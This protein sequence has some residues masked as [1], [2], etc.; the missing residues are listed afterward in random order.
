MAR[1]VA[2]LIV[3]AYRLL[4]LFFKPETFDLSAVCDLVI[5]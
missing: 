3:P 4:W 5:W 2:M 1:P